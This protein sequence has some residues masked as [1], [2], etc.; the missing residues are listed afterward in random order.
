[1][2][3]L[4]SSSPILVHLS[5]SIYLTHF[6]LVIPS[7]SPSSTSLSFSQVSFNLFSLVGNSFSFYFISELLCCLFPP[8]CLCSTGPSCS[9]KRGTLTSVMCTTRHAS[10][11]CAK[12]HRSFYCQRGRCHHDWPDRRGTSSAV[13]T[14]CR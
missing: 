6:I 9:I 1:M 14:V 7:L 2:P 10:M 4:S 12:A 5:R 13:Q 3:S 11:C 8:F